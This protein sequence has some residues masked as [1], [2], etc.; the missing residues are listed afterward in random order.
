MKP[1]IT[2]FCTKNIPN[3]NRLSINGL[4]NNGSV[5]IVRF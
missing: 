4:I 1:M 5:K 2:E 3:A